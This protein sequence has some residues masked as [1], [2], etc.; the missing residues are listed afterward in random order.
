MN[1][2]SYKKSRFS[3]CKPQKPLHLYGVKLRNIAIDDKENDYLRSNQK[4]KGN[5]AQKENE[6]SYNE[7]QLSFYNSLEIS[8]RKYHCPFK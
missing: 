6:P 4:L 7:I 5:Q 3:A 8:P 1:Q 2:S